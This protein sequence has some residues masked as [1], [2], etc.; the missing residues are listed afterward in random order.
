M[1]KKLLSSFADVR[2]KTI[3][4]G[5]VME[6]RQD[7]EPILEFVKHR[8]Q[9]P[10]DKDFK[11]I[12]EMPLV[13][14]GAITAAIGSEESEPE[15]RDDPLRVT[16]LHA[17]AHPV[18]LPAEGAPAVDGELLHAGREAR[19]TPPVPVPVRP[20]VVLGQGVLLRGRRGGRGP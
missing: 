15:R 5:G 16:I 10:D 14:F 18:R 19:R 13:T 3:L 7:A 6:T 9:L 17:D 2:K 8:S 1:S 4:H 20:R 12:G 11:F